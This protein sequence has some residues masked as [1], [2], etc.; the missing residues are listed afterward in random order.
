MFF[1]A[2]RVRTTP[3]CGECAVGQVMLG[4]RCF[5]QHDVYEQ[6]L[7][8]W[9]LCSAC[10]ANSISGHSL[11]IHDL[12]ETRFH[13]SSVIF[14]SSYQ[15]LNTGIFFAETSTPIPHRSFLASKFAHRCFP[16]HV[17]S[18]SWHFHSIY[19]RA[20]REFTSKRVWKCKRVYEDI[21]DVNEEHIF[22]VFTSSM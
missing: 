15:N 11:K 9:M 2:W 17:M 6:L 22:D 8:D 18:S 1:T 16:S 10:I 3:P 20:S 7:R 13:E 19:K 21:F 14:A 12:E 5:L 4:R